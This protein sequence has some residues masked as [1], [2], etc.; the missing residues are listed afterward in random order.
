MFVGENPTFNLPQ[1]FDDYIS[2]NNNPSS[3]PTRGATSKN[4]KKNQSIVMDNSI[5]IAIK[6]LAHITKDTL[7]ELIKELPSEEKFQSPNIKFWMC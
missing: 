7:G 5:V 1:D 4:K 3:K 2:E 6:N